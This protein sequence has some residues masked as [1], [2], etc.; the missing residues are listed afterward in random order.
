M[1]SELFATCLVD[2]FLLSQ[3][4][5]P[6]W[7]V[8]SDTSKFFKWLGVLLGKLEK[9]AKENDNVLRADTGA[10]VPVAKCE[11]RKIGHVIIRVVPTPKKVHA[12][13][14][15]VLLPCRSNGATQRAFE[16]ETGC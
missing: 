5:L 2:G 16:S 8:S 12:G 6:A 10:L 15:S 13:T 9:L 14:L 7:Q 4:F 1:Q 3:H 11:Q